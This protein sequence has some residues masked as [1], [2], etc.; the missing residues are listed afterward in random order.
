MRKLPNRAVEVNI[1]RKHSLV[2]VDLKNFGQINQIFGTQQANDF[3]RNL[4]QELAKYGVV[5]SGYSAVVSVVKS[6]M[7][8][9]GETKKHQ[10]EQFK[11]IKSNYRLTD[12]QKRY[13]VDLYKGEVSI[14]TSQYIFDQKNTMGFSIFSDLLHSVNN[15]HLLGNKIFARQVDTVVVYDTKNHKGVALIPEY[16]DAKTG[17]KISRFIKEL[18]D[19]DPAD[20]HGG[21]VAID[22]VVS[23]VKLNSDTLLNFHQGSAK[24]LELESL[25]S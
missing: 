10:E 21:D 22:N 2:L 8:I 13:L 3:L 5:A 23:F 25:V 7:S 11:I 6:D 18:N 20:R 12:E 19:F 14:P 9:L 4:R 16:Y 15:L 1:D 24:I 17:E